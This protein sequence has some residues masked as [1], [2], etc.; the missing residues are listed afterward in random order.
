MTKQVESAFTRFFREKSGF[1]KFKSKKSPIQSFPIPQYYN[2]NFENNTVKLPKIGEST[3]VLHKAFEGELKT[4]TIS[5]SRTGDYCINI[6][7]DDGREPQLN[8]VFEI[9]D[10]RD[11]R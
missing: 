7:V 1:P 11:R 9:H 4:A 10:Y 6:L 3:A 2:V 8:Y 5:K